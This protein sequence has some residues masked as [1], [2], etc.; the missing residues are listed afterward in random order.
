MVDWGR[1]IKFAAQKVNVSLNKINVMVNVKERIDLLV[2]E[3]FENKTELKDKMGVSFV[4]IHNWY[5]KNKIPTKQVKKLCVLCPQV[6]YEW[7][8]TG[9]GDMLKENVAGE[10][11]ADAMEQKR[12]KTH[13]KDKLI[14]FYEDVMVSCGVV[15]MPEQREDSC[16]VNMP[17]VDA[18]FLM[19]ASGNSMSPVIEN[20][21]LIG[22]KEMSPFEGFR[23]SQPYLIITRD[24]H[25]MVKY[26]RNPGE[27][28]PYLELSTANPEYVMLQSEKQ[29]EK[30]SII[31]IMK[32]SFVGKV[33]PF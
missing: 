16:L 1:K 31:K 29:L 33:K 24:A 18:Q 19:R 30:E 28:V 13:V 21:D 15:E 20:G 8:S 3:F 4:S 7:L 2:S 9:E 22:V 17:G 32:V 5:T 12:E 11:N 26:V 10:G 6:R 25:C 27:N 14:P 23:N